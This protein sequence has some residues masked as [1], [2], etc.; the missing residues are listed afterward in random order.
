M[1]GGTVGVESALGAGSKFW[2][3]LPLEKVAAASAG[4]AP[5]M[6]RNGR[7][8]LVVEKHKTH[9]QVLSAQLL[10]AGYDTSESDC[11]VRA[12][13]ALRQGL[14]DNRPY[15]LVFADHE[16]EDMDGAAFADQISSDPHLSRSRVVLLTSLNQQGD[17][18]RFASLGFAGRLTKPI[19]SRE[20][21][22]CI[23]RVLARETREWRVHTQPIATRAALPNGKQTATFKGSVLLVEDNA[24]NQKVA[25]RILE[26]M[27]CTV[28]IA[29]DGEKAVQAFQEARFDLILMDLQMP[30]MDGYGATHRIR[31]LESDRRTPIVALSANAM[32]GQL[33][34]CLAEDM[35]GFL[36]KPL[37]IPRLRETLERYGFADRH[38]SADHS[39]DAFRAK[40]SASPR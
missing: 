2:F 10:H 23:D 7:R 38:E 9:R 26:R 15:D 30:V 6:N 12:L 36:T 33:E 25:A 31:E 3:A 32:N 27:G 39:D 18:N 29:E 16:M 24:V 22:D 21:F 1:M 8:V 34:R 5:V 14:A 28:R 11:G 40:G 13:Q 17:A 20:L 19:R 37:E 35:D 4:D